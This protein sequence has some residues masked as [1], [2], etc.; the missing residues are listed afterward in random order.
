MNFASWLKVH[1]AE[2]IPAEVVAFN[3]NLYESG[4]EG[5]YDVQLVGCASYDPEDPDWA[6]DARYSTGEDLYTFTSG[7][8]EEALE[9]FLR[10][11]KD[12]L[13]AASADDRLARARYLTAGF[14]DGDLEVIR[15]GN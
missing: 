8:W 12:Y 15:E 6:C 14:V 5:E 3:F 10:M 4:T 7:E 9:E 13:A 1:L 2:G 11:V